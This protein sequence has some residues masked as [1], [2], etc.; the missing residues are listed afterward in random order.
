MNVHSF[1][2]HTLGYS[3]DIFDLIRCCMLMT[4]TIHDDGQPQQPLPSGWLTGLAS[5]PV[6]CSW[7]AA[8]A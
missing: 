3:S 4:T 8:A 1:L 6:G 7:M 5:W 2:L